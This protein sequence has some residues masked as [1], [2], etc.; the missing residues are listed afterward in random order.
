MEEDGIYPDLETLIAEIPDDVTN[1]KLY[2]SADVEFL[3][4]VE[5]MD[6][7]QEVNLNKLSEHITTRA[8][9]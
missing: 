8:L 1:S 5:V 7:V 9:Y 4:V 6:D 2:I 3:D